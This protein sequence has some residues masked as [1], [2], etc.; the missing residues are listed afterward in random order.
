MIVTMLQ[1]RE[2]TI[3]TVI[4]PKVPVWAWKNPIVNLLI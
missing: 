2:Q 4:L 1:R 3:A